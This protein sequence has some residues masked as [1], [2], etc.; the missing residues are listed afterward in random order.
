MQNTP[1]YLEIVEIVVQII[2]GERAGIELN[3]CLCA[4]NIPN[5]DY[6]P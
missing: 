4:I 6:V 3:A 2:G 5:Q 1:K